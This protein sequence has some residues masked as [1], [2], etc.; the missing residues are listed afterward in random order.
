MDTGSVCVCVCG[1]G[2]PAVT[3]RTGM[4]TA[5]G[6]TESRGSIAYLVTKDAIS[7]ASGQRALKSVASDNC[8]LT[9][10]VWPKKAHPTLQ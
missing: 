3:L 2:G 1:G 10:K 6:V 8:L 7:Q 9:S 5:Q 4:S